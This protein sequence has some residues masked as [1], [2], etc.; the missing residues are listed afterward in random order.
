MKIKQILLFTLFFAT[1]ITSLFPQNIYIL[2]LFAIATFLMLPANKWWNRGTAALLLFSIFY[3]IMIILGG[4]MNSVFLTIS[5][6]IAPVAFYRFGH[7][8]LSVFKEE[9]ARFKFLF[10]AVFAYLVHLFIINYIDIS[11]VGIVNEDRTFLGMGQDKDALSATLYGLMASVGIGCVATLFAS[12]SKVLTR[13][14]FLV[15]VVS[16]MLVVVH[17]V[18]RGGLVVFAITLLLSIFVYCWKNKIKLVTTILFFLILALSLFYLDVI[19]NDIL[20]AYN[21]RHDIQGYETMTAGGRTELWQISIR[22]LLSNPLGWEQKSYAHNLFLDLA[23]LGG[24][25]SLLPFLAAAIMT[26]KR[27]SYI[28]KFSSSSFSKTLVVLNIAL[29]IAS[30]IEPVIEGSMLYFS[31]MMMFWGMIDIIST[32]RS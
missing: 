2:D 18:N 29:L 7:Y 19:S 17:L 32:E 21:Q 30:S 24:W 10:Y 23:R 6:L 9:N 28:L 26:L 3:A 12:E 11:I 27:M 16:S 20:M 14:L 25:I 1:L 13:I 22:N 4:H 8:A 31:L 15:L 5:Y